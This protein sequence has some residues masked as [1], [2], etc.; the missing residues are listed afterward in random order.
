MSGHF[1][2]FFGAELGPRGPRRGRE[3]RRAVVPLRP[4]PGARRGRWSP[5]TCAR[6]AGCRAP[7]PATPSP[8]PTTRACCGR[9]RC[10]SRCCRSR[11][12][13]PARPTR[14]SCRRRSAG[15]P[16]RTR[17]SGSRTT[18]RPT[19]W[20]IWCMGEAHADVIMER[21]AERYSVHVDQVPFVVSLRETF[22]GTAKGH[23]RHVKQSGGHGQYAVCDIEVE[24]LPGGRRVRVRR[25]GRRRRRYR[26]TSS[27][28]S[29][30]ACARRWS[31][32]SAT[33]TRSSTCG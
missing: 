12:S 31:G 23:G 1:T 2:S 22:A 6:S 13:P 10:P 30:R 32:A 15:S 16:P 3:G 26:A 18:A 29:R 24:P 4:H 19:S 9:G 27:R 11:S 5:A 25:Q 21:L 20:C 28:P 8:R 17:A 14:T 33:A 7:R